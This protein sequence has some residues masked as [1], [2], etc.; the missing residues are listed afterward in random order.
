VGPAGGRLAIRAWTALGIFP[1]WDPVV[2]PPPH[3]QSELVIDTEEDVKRYPSNHDVSGLLVNGIR[4]G[5]RAFGVLILAAG[6]A[7]VAVMVV[8]GPTAVA[9]WMGDS[10]A[11]GGPGATRGAEPCTVS[12]AA[13]LL[14][15]APLL[16]L[17][18][19][20]MV[21]GLRPAHA[22]RRHAPRM[23]W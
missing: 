9:E 21:L 19:G 5:L 16:I 1:G 17:A 7:A 18:G 22:R 4:I 13:E 10:C 12:D 6:L 20:A 11:W 2:S 3:P 15:C 14:I 8:P 23:A